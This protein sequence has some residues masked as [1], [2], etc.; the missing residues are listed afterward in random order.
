MVAG[1]ILA[2]QKSIV[3]EEVREGMKEEH[4]Y[5]KKDTK[6]H[7]YMVYPHIEIPTVEPLW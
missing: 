3:T 1:L 7:W 6:G 5:W 4:P 2:E